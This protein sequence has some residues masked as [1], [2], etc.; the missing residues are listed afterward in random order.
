MTDIH[1]DMSDGDRL[2][3]LLA[4]EQ[5]LGLDEE[6]RLELEELIYGATAAEHERRAFERASASAMVAMTDTEDC[7]ADIKAA[8]QASIDRYTGQPGAMEAKPTS[9]E[10]ELIER[11]S[12]GFHY[13]GWFA[14]AA[15]FVLAVI[16]WWP[17]PVVGPTDGVDRAMADLE[18][19]P[20]AVTLEWSQWDSQLGLEG[21][22][23]VPGVTG[24]VV[25][26]DAK[27]TGFMTFEGLPEL[28]DAD[29]QLWIVD[30]ERG[31]DQRISGAVFEGHPEGGRVVVPI[32]P[33]QIPV[34]KAAAFAVTIEKPGGTWVSDMSRRVVITT[35]G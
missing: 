34:E 9:A 29:Y 12:L 2:M 18:G 31:L 5:T 4:D 25:W 20:D 35:R 1:P 30:A 15:C 17:T 32:D 23:E 26:S 16:A 13:A 3:E 14:A 33:K 21:R 8:L 27:Q 24:E 10:R 22:A 11:R 28:G 6:R 7:P 19:A